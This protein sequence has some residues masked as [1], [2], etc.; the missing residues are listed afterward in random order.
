ML[1]WLAAEAALRA[2]RGS[3]D[4]STTGEVSS[5]SGRWFVSSIKCSSVSPFKKLPPLKPSL[6]THWKN[7]ENI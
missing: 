5:L 2:L 4:A 7:I 6:Y 3:D 1:S